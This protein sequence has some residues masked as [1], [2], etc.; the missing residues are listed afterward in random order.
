MIQPELAVVQVNAIRVLVSPKANPGS[1]D[2]DGLP[3]S[4]SL[5]KNSRKADALMTLDSY[6]R[7]ALNAGGS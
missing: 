7:A 2:D 1:S 6:G 4:Y 3:A 5:P